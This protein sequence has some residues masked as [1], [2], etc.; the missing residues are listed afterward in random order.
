MPNNKIPWMILPPEEKTYCLLF[1]P[2]DREEKGDV[3]T[4]SPRL[5]KTQHLGDDFADT[6][7]LATSRS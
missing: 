2:E 7:C 3:Q 4:N 5:Y 1:N 6:L